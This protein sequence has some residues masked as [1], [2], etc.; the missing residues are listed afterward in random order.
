[1]VW[2]V[3]HLKATWPPNANLTQPPQWCVPRCDSQCSSRAKRV[4]RRRKCATGIPFWRAFLP[5]GSGPAGCPG[6]GGWATDPV[7][8]ELDAGI[9]R[10][11]A[12]EDGVVG[13]ARYGVGVDQPDRAADLRCHFTI[14]RRKADRGG[15]R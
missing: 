10:F 5:G 12:A 13:R 8:D 15:H 4:G 14:G 3:S 6:P 9:V 1:M 11:R 2:L 7:I